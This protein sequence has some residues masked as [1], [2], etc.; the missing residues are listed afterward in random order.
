MEA[1]KKSLWEQE[2]GRLDQELQR[3]QSTLDNTRQQHDSDKQQA[4]K[5]AADAKDE[6]DQVGLHQQACINAGVTDTMVDGSV[7]EQRQKWLGLYVEGID[8]ADAH[9]HVDDSRRHFTVFV[10]CSCPSLPMTTGLD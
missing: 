5:Q 6:A 1:E 4:L 8:G 9:Q 10:C 7:C 2:K 3:L